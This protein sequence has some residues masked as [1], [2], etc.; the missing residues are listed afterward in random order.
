MW[1]ENNYSKKDA[2]ILYTTLSFWLALLTSQ[3]AVYAEQERKKTGHSTITMYSQQLAKMCLL[4][5][6]VV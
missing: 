5:L 6:S 4:H 3:I 2:Y 1:F